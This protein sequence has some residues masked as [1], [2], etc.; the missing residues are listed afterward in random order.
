VPA[1]PLFA[2]GHEYPPEGPDA[3][4]ALP[5]TASVYDGDLPPSPLAEDPL[6]SRGEAVP[7]APALAEARS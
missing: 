5:E 2:T 6:Y 3:Y 1:V 4:G 7:A